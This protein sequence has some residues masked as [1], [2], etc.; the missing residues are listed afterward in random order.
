VTCATA[1][2]LMLTAD[3]AELAG[4]T[5]S[6][7]TLHIATCASCRG[8]AALLLE[9]QGELARVLDAPGAQ[10]SPTAVR[11]ALATA[12]RRRDDARRRRWTLPLAAAAVLAGLM[13]IRFGSRAPVQP[14]P[15]AVPPAAGHRIT[16]TAPQGRN[17]AVL[18]TDNP[19]VVII[20][21]F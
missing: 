15:P 2:T 11:S 5:G 12:R 7:L 14:S 1:R 21:F 20:W 19:N 13:V 4:S 8:R 10:D 9:A 17:V 16:V 6:D 18:Q 3:P